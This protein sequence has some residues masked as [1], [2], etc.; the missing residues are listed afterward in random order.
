M[1]MTRGSL[2]A[3]TVG[4]LAVIPL[5]LRSLFPRFAASVSRGLAHGFVHRPETRLALE[6]STDEELDP[7]T[8]GGYTVDEMAV[9]VTNALRAMGLTC[10]FARIVLIVGHGSAS[11]NNPHEAGA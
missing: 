6:R 11:L 1:T 4:L 8:T 5:A 9:I 3:F 7:A 2:L 10:S